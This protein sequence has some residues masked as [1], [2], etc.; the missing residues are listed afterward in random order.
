MDLLD[1]D[2]LPVGAEE[3]PTA[4]CYQVNGSC[5]RTVHPLDIQL[6]IYLACAVGMLITVLGNL[7]VVFA[8]SYFKVFHTPTNLLLLYLALAD[9]FLGLLHRSLSRELLVLWRL[10]LLPAYLLDTLFCLT[11]IFHLCFISIDRH[12][13]ICEPLIYPSKF[14]VRVAIRYILAGFLWLPQRQA[15]QIITLSKNLAGAAKHE[16]KAAKTLGIAVGIYLLCWLPFTIDTLVDSLLNFITPPLV[17]HIFIWFAYFNSACNPIIYVF[18]YRWFR[19]AL[20]LCL[21]REISSR[22]HTIDLVQNLV[23][24]YQQLSTDLTMLKGMTV[25]PTRKSAPA[26]EAIKK[27]AG[28]CSCLKC[29]TEVITRRF[30]NTASKD[31]KPNAEYRITLDPKTGRPNV[32]RADKENLVVSMSG[33]SCGI[34]DF[35][36]CERYQPLSTDLTARKGMT[37]TPTKKSV[38]ARDAIRKLSDLKNFTTATID[39]ALPGSLSVYVKDTVSSTCRTPHVIGAH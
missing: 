7:F 37:A 6:A 15:Q 28:A 32:S 11:S 23:P 26:R 1:K 27:L 21:S 31:A 5:P 8:V 12:C 36:S 39:G 20:R 10:P 4:F 38:Q 29:K 24:K 3:H 25:T 13:A 35:D 16:R 22:T 9:M 19:K 2:I 18:S 30:P 34:Q 14:T 17:F 33:S